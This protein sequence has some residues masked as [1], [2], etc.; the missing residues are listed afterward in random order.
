MAS[1]W[2]MGSQRSPGAQPLSRRQLLIAAG[3]V[4]SAWAS[5]ISVRRAFAAA[6]TADAVIKDLLDGNKRFTS[7]QAEAPR[8]QPSDFAKVA[9]GQSPEAVIVGCADSRVPPVLL[10][11]QGVGDL[12]VV[13]VAGNVVS[14]AWPTVKGSI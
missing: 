11:D 8:R 1:C 3:A 2:P 14:G 6:P 12:F 13:R 5:P 9:E 4:A 7:G 10:F